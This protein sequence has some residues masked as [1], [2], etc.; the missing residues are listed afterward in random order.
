MKRLTFT[1]VL[2]I[3]PYF[4]FAQF[5]LGIKTAVPF[6]NANRPFG[7]LNIDNVTLS[8]MGYFPVL[9]F[10]GFIHYSFN[11]QLALQAEIK[12]TYEGFY[13]YNVD[14]VEGVG[15]NF[16]LKFIEMPLLVQ[17]N[18][19]NKFRWF[20]QTGL[21][22]KYLLTFE[23][24]VDEAENKVENNIVLISTKKIEDK[25]NNFVLKANVGTGFML[26]FFQHF[27]L[28]G[29]MR[30]GYDITPIINEV[31]FLKLEMT[32]GVAYKI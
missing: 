23:Y 20:V 17:G 27:M 18:W 13:Y 22:L 5:S 11:N 21:S 16:L 26:S 19:G 30:W 25:L 1:I 29:E 24:Y 32:I 4:V 8:D 28:T 3:I 6:F 31:R 7:N 10:G 9:N 2:L 14:K 12:Y 15:N